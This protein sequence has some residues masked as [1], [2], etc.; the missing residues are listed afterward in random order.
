[1][2]L[3]E[4]SRPVPSWRIACLAVSAILIFDLVA[5][6]ASRTLGFRYA[7]ATLG[8]WLIYAITGFVAA[9]HGGVAAAATAGAVVGFAE[10][11]LG[12]AISWLIGPGRLPSG[13]PSLGRIASTVLT[14]TLIGAAVS[15]LGG[16]AGRRPPRPGVEAS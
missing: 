2:D 9:R 15:A 12:W 1:M 3:H 16:V 14:V 6:L 8:S 13:T 11:T 10:A 4:D 5:S 7:Y